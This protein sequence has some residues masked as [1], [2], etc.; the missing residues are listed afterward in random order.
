MTIYYRSYKY[1]PKATFIS[2][3]ANVGALL[4]GVGAFVCLLGLENKA[5]GIPVGIVLAALALFLFIYVGR[6]LTDKLAE[7]WS[8]ENIRT[9]ARFAYLYVCENPGEYEKIAAINPDF[10]AK[11]EMGENG[12][13]VKRK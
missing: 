3:A 12:K 13:P 4:A 1:S 7:K 11:Y 5:V 10:A 6:K 2:A 9:K 8:E